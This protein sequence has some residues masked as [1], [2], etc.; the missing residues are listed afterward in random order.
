MKKY[1]R[2]PIASPMSVVFTTPASHWFALS[3]SWRSPIAAKA[4]ANMNAKSCFK[5]N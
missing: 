2:P 4:L 5:L 3:M 1:K